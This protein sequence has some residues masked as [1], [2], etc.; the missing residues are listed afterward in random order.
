MKSGI[1]LCGHERGC[2]PA[3]AVA[4]WLFA[5]VSHGQQS[6]FGPTVATAVPVATGWPATPPAR[7]YVIP[8]AMEPGL[9]EQLQQQ[10]EATV[11]PQG[12]VR[13]LFAARPRVADMV[14][15][16]DPSLPV[17]TTIAKLLA[18]ELAQAG[19]PAV[20]WSEPTPPPPDGWRLGGQV[21][22]LDDG[23]AAA[24]NMIGFGVGNK[25]IGI[26]VAMSDP[27]TADG[28]AFFILDTS[29]KGRKMPGTLSVAAVAGFNPYVVVGKL[30]ASSS[31]IAD[32]TQQRRLADEIAKAVA[33]AV[34]LHAATPAR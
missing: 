1:R 23:N 12:P 5:A 30:A 24:R 17:G 33:E 3:L 32:I 9:Q 16:N 34:S 19:W 21:V 27:K 8:F 13:K 4:A 25:S 29:D 14:M 22:S 26:D 7:I 20:F 15:G 18:D 31:G 10:A 28:Q 6:A 11:I 2:L